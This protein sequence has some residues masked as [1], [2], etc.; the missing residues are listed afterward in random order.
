[1]DTYWTQGR[2]GYRNSGYFMD[3]IYLRS[4]SVS[5]HGVQV[6]GQPKIIQ[7]YFRRGGA[8]KICDLHLKM[9]TSYGFITL[10]SPFFVFIDF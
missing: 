9:P 3:V 8:L 2:W 10:I 5:T 1:M 4:I 7:K 6:G